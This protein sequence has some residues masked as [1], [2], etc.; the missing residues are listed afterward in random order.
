[1]SDQ[2]VNEKKTTTFEQLMKSGKHVTKRIRAFSIE[3]RKKKIIFI[4]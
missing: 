4:Y 2:L 3:K 1:M